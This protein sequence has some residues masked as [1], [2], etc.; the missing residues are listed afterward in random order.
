[1]KQSF[2]I[3]RL[4][5]YIDII[6]SDNKKKHRLDG[7]FLARNTDEKAAGDGEK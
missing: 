5:K 1:M 6:Q 3:K 7:W 2:N 4:N